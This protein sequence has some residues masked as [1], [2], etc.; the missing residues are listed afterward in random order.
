MK[1]MLLIYGAEDAWT[2]QER[3][4][5]MLDSMKLCDDLAKTGKFMHSS[6]LHSVTMATCLRV[7][8]GKRQVTDGPFAET[9]EQLGGY[10]VIDVENLDEALEFAATLPPA[11]K[12]TVEV[13]PLYPLPARHEESPVKPREGLAFSRVVP[14]S[15]DF[16]YRAYTDPELLK[17]WFCPKPW[18][19][20][21]ARLDPR[22]GGAFCTVMVGPEG[23][24]MEHEGVYLEVV[25]GTRVVFTDA[26]GPGWKPNSGLFMT[27]VVT[28]TPEGEGTRYTARVEHWTDEAEKAHAEM[29]FVEG[30][31][32]ALDQLVELAASE[33]SVS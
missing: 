25:P 19:V 31:N 32:K 2:E 30:W 29:G 7:R 4:Q 6:P 23:E 3:E 8:D 21:S 12:G 11:K 10:Y 16:L 27:A 33:L 24:K 18:R 20:S 22:P 13:R 14:L 28:F 9:T 26:Y 17:Q 5:C 15:S 1:Y